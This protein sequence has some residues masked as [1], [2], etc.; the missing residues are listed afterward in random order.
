MIE[1]RYDYEGK[2]LARQVA[3]PELAGTILARVGPE[4]PLGQLAKA[5][6]DIREMVQSDVLQHED[7]LVAA[8]RAYLLL[9]MS[10]DP[11][12]ANIERCLFGWRLFDH[13]DAYAPLLERNEGATR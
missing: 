13:W 7:G 3:E 8:E 12:Q 2:R 10:R 6:P 1:D 5:I 9:E 11:T 4:E